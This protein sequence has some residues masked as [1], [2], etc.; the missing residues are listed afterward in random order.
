ME[1]HLQDQLAALSYLRDCGSRSA[2]HCRRR[3]LIRWNSTIL[4]AEKGLGLRAAVD[5]A[6]AAQNWQYA[7]ELRARMIQAVQHSQMPIFFIQARMTTI[8]RR[9]ATRRRNGK[10]RQAARPPNISCFGKS[11]QDAH[12]FCVHGG[13]VWGPQVFSFLTYAVQ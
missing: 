1:Q 8:L 5:F 11:N 6:G 10:I 3:L 13:E 12:E 2:T 7:P 9:A 4:M